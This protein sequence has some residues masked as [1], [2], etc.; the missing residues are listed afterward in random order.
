MDKD[1]LK[2]LVEDIQTPLNE[3]KTELEAEGKDDP[4]IDKE[5]LKRLQNDIQN[6]LNQL[7]TELEKE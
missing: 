4:K 7:K 2:S 5:L 6:L 1:T 3:I